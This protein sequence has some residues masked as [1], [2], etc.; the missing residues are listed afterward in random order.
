V[1]R[2]GFLQST[3]MA[4]EVFFENGDEFTQK[5]FIVVDAS[6]QFLEIDSMSPR[7]SFIFLHLLGPH[8]MV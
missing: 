6:E 3:Q 1:P 5:F 8:L 7:W 2:E 4:G